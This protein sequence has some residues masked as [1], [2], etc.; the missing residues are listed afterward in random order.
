MLG[1]RVS[2]STIS[3][4]PA[5]I[6]SRGR[7]MGGGGGSPNQGTTFRGQIPRPKD[8]PN[9]QIFGGRRPPKVCTLG[10]SPPPPI[11]EL[12]GARGGMAPDLQSAAI[13]SDQRRLRI[14]EHPRTRGDLPVPLG[15]ANARKDA[16]TVSGARS[17]AGAPQSALMA[18]NWQ[19]W[20]RGGGCNPSHGSDAGLGCGF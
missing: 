6:G 15:G 18:D 14:G 1:E 20:Q 13:L 5:P 10:R 12:A 3:P 11:G 7:W 19:K 4:I 9:V 2:P 17:W 8:L 16:P